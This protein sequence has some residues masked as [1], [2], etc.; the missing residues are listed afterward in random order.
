MKKT[1]TGVMQRVLRFCDRLILIDDGST[2]DTFE[3]VKMI[4]SNKIT[5]LRHVINLG[6]GAALQTGFDFARKIKTSVV[7]TFDADGQ[8]TASEI[9]RLIEPV[10]LGQADVVL[11]SRFLGKTINIPLVRFIVLRLGLIFTRLYSGLKLTDTHNGFR[12][13]S[14]KALATLDIK[15]NRW[16]HPSDIIYQIS[17]NKLRIKEVPVT[18]KYTNYSIRKG[19]KNSE[20]LK[21]PFELISKA[22]LS[23]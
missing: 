10:I 17:K 23:K 20:A 5:V 12:A 6:Q 1:I 21:I 13:F 16:A 18:V 15:H 9:S 3:K 22:L 14:G 19:Q 4:R 7:V 8:Q 2:D 11:G